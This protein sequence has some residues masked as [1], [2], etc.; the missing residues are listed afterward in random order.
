MIN[1]L[2]EIYK[3]VQEH[4]NEPLILTGSMAI[5]WYLIELNINKNITPN[6]YDFV[7][8]GKALDNIRHSKM[9]IQINN[10]NNTF[11]TQQNV[12]NTSLTFN[13]NNL[14]F[15]ISRVLHKVRYSTHNNINIIN[16]YDLKKD[17]E[18]LDDFDEKY[19]SAT[20]K[21]N[22]INEII[23]NIKK[24]NLENKFNIDKQNN[25]SSEN[26]ELIKEISCNLF[27]DSDE[28]Y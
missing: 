24:N 8:T 23:D 6:D 20:E 26:Y 2:S 28:E 5:F 22:I 19:E 4:I 17:Y 18:M 1:N 3:G 21:I 9:E 12:P 13:S 25:N 16:I 11:T 15:D 14:S 7:F 27:G 10:K